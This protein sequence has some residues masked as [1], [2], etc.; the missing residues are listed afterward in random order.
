MRTHALSSRFI[1][2]WQTTAP[3]WTPARP[4][5]ISSFAG[6]SLLFS[7]LRRRQTKRTRRFLRSRFLVIRCA[8]LAGKRVARL[9][10]AR[11][12]SPLACHLRAGREG[13]ARAARGDGAPKRSVTAYL[14]QSAPLR[15][16]AAR[17]RLGIFCLIFFVPPIVACVVV[18]VR[19]RCATFKMYFVHHPVS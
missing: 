17:G 11:L 3:P 2:S 13:A 10:P 6:P 12:T 1:G 4:R 15:D 8:L 16:R 19:F 5:R 14:D 9:R 7:L 18:F